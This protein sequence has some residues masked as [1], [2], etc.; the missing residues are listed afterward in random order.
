[1]Q[2]TKANIPLQI[3]MDMEEKKRRRSGARHRYN[4]PTQDVLKKMFNFKLF[5]SVNHAF[6][7]YENIVRKI[8][9]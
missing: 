9:A 3:L 4:P 2:M 6:W 5:E 7:E 1:M 8:L